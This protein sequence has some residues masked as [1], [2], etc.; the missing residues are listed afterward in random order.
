MNLT[1]ELL[2]AAY[3]CPLSRAQKWAGPLDAAATQFAINSVQRMAMWLAHI[4]IESGR[5]IYTSEIW[6]PT[7]AQ[8]AYERDFGAAWPPTALDRRNALAYRLGNAEVGD[9]RTYA[10]RGPLQ[11]TGRKNHALAR[12][13]MRALLGPDVPDF[14]AEPRALED[15]RWGALYCG[16]FWVDGASLNFSPAALRHCGPGANLNDLA[17]RGDV[18]GTTLAING[19]TTHLSERGALYAHIR[20]VLLRV[21]A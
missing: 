14:E 13:Y 5:L 7:K 4:G 20:G 18:V 16:W 2:I 12:D 1:P 11:C 19:G 3:S 21:A 17:D 9:G 15:P 8:L 10:G 6:G